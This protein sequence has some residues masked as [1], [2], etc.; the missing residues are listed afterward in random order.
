MEMEGAKLSNF[1]NARGL[2]P[3]KE[4][5]LIIIHSESAQSVRCQRKRISNTVPLSHYLHT[6]FYNSP[7]GSIVPCTLAVTCPR[8][9]GCLEK[10]VLKTSLVAPNSIF[11]LL[12]QRVRSDLKRLK[13]WLEVH[14]RYDATFFLRLLSSHCAG[15]RFLTHFRSDLTRSLLCLKNELCA[16]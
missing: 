3:R 13:N 15:S 10:A 12:K 11:K 1:Q 5:T 6:F 7:P 4:F 8:S 9:F 14:A 2:K 16:S